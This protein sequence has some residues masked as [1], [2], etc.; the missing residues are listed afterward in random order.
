MKEN[1]GFDAMRDY[2]ATRRSVPANSLA[3]PAPDDATLQTILTMAVRVPDHGKLAP[4]RFIVFE[5]DASV[6]AGQAF[7]R[8]AGGTDPERAQAEAERFSRAAMVIAVVSRAA[9]HPK[10]PEWE[11]VLSAG[12]VCLNLIHAAAAHG[13]RAQWLTEW[14]AYDERARAAIGLAPDE[15]VAGF[16]YLGRAQI[17][18]TERARPVV[19]ELVT[20]FQA[21]NVMGGSPDVEAV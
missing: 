6:A 3:G 17:V 13:F 2:L 9:E 16:I 12:A 15:R 19:A 11:Q 4:W 1:A 8:I 5:G 10:I 18:P 14:I 7:A 21:Q 20:R